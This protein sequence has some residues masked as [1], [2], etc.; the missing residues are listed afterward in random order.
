MSPQIRSNKLRFRRAPSRC[1]RFWQG[2]LILAT[3]ALA[4]AANAQSACYDIFASKHAPLRPGNSV[5]L[6]Y[7]FTDASPTMFAKA[8]IRAEVISSSIRESHRLHE[9][10]A[11]LRQEYAGLESKKSTAAVARKGE[12]VGAIKVNRAALERVNRIED[13]ATSGRRLGPSEVDLVR[14]HKFEQTIVLTGRKQAALLNSRIAELN[15]NLASLDKV[16]LPAGRVK[17]VYRVAVKHYFVTLVLVAAAAGLAQNGYDLYVAHQADVNAPI[18]TQ[19]YDGGES[20][21]TR[22]APAHDNV[23][24]AVGN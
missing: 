1:Q 6:R 16:K 11:R 23:G 4:V 7:S 17:R 5:T 14:S 18:V 21:N 10:G 2:I 13:L 12:L 9:E 19:I 24:E 22:F 3:L 20:G 8:D 15:G